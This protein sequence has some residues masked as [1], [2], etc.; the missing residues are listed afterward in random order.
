MP[1]Q[2]PSRRARPSGPEGTRWCPKC[3]TFKPREEFF[4]AALTKDG[5]SSYCASC[6]R[7]DDNA[8]RRRRG[9]PQR[10]NRN[11]PPDHRWCPQ[12]DTYRPLKEFGAG[13]KQPGRPCLDCS[14]KIAAQRRGGYKQGPR[15]S[16]A[17]QPP[18][19]S[20]TRRCTKCHEIKPLRTFARS[21]S[22]Y[23]GRCKACVAT[24]GRGWIIKREVMNAY[25]GRCVCCGESELVFLTIDHI[26]NDG[27][28]HRREIGATGGFYFWL[29]RHGFPRDR[30][31]VCCFN[32]NRAKYILGSLDRCPHRVA[33]PEHA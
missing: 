11:A 20:G 10:V 4:R 13:A 1:K 6:M 24:E 17:A 9:I 14:A 7:A 21:G 29:K 2:Q 31:Q 22:S 26:H 32:C 23:R 18:L 19:E 12:C 30:F 8:R 27:A 5:T 15:G 33:A 28:I 3:Q 16:Y 25:G